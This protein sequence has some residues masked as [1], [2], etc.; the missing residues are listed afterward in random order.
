MVVQRTRE[1]G[2]RIALGAQRGDVM[3]LVLV[4]GF[5]LILIGVSFGLGSAVALTRLMRSLLFGVSPLDSLTFGAVAI[6]LVA[7]AIVSCFLPVRRAMSTD[8]VV[9]LRY[10]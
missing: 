4:H 10:E 3:R 1:V 9:A 5:R 6:V 7:T 8:P 2:I